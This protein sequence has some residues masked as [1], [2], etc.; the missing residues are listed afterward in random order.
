MSIQVINACRRCNVH[1]SKATSRRK[2]HRGKTGALLLNTTEIFAVLLET[3]HSLNIK[4]PQEDTM[5]PLTFKVY[6]L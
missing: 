1:S 6:L 3:Y 2:A 5:V 4:R